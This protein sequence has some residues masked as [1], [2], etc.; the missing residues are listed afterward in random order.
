M[1]AVTG[2]YR[3]PVASLAEA[4]TTPAELNAASMYNTA[5][6]ATVPQG[7]PVSSICVPLVSN[8]NLST[9]CYMACY[10]KPS[11][12]TKT[13]LAV[14]SN[15]L[16]WSPG[17]EL[18]WYFDSPFTIAADSEFVFHLIKS[19]A[20]ATDNPALPGVHLM[21][22]IAMGLSGYGG[23]VRYGGS[24]NNPNRAPYIIFNTDCAVTS[25][26]AAL[27]CLSTYEKVGI[28][29][30][31]ANKDALLH[32]ASTVAQSAMSYDSA[33]STLDEL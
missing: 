24:W 26:D 28:L 4:P 22:R 3:R 21:C 10:N 9:P 30:L 8:T 12:G 18:T 31:L 11:G 7:I 5:G 32:L 27:L 23:S 15:A 25:E 16:T 1:G 13:L 2:L 14:S 17:D 29:Q 6:I 33:V 20:D 19:K